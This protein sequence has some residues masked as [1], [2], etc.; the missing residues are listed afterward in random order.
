[1]PLAVASRFSAGYE[2]LCFSVVL[3]RVRIVCIS[4]L[5]SNPSLDVGMSCRAARAAVPGLLL[6][7]RTGGG[8]PS[9]SIADMLGMVCPED[10]TGGDAPAEAWGSDGDFR[11]DDDECWL[12]A[13]CAESDAAGVGCCV[14]GSACC[15]DCWPYEGVEG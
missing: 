7:A 3:S 9:L 10:T 11:S 14:C 1:M 12:S 15:C 5:A 8:P 6:L 4:R 2:K 13:I